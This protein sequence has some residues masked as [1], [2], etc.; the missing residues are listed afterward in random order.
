MHG[1]K[2]GA[3]LRRQPAQQGDHGADLV[4][5][6]PIEGLVQEQQ[7][8]GGQQGDGQQQASAVALGEG[9]GGFGP[10]RGEVQRRLHPPRRVRP[11]PERGGEQ[12]QQGG[13][14]H[15]RIGLYP[16]RE[17]EQRAAQRRPGRGL[18]L[19]LVRHLQAGDT[20]HEGGLARP[21]GPD[22]T[23]DLGRADLQVDIPARAVTAP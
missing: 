12:L 3:A 15:L 17:I 11:M 8:L 22:Q 20:G 10:H 23:Q 5:V 19:T 1:R 21:I 4:Q 14:P 6:Q 13:H 9:P 16:L 2:Q 7:R 18:H